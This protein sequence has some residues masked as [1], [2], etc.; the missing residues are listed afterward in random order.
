M[1]ITFQQENI[2]ALVRYYLIPQL[3]HFSIFTFQ[4]PLGAGKTTIIKELLKQCNIK[5]TITSPTFS[6]VNSYKNNKNITFYHFDLY[7][8]DSI[9]TFYFLGLNEYFYKKYS[10]SLLEWPEVINPI[11]LEKDLEPSVFPI[12]LEYNSTDICQRNVMLTKL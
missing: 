6:Y 8:I 4:G 12:I 5:K 10:L 7:R 1:K 2:P 9:E 3:K 11:L